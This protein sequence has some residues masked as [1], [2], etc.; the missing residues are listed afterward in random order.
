MVE[1]LLTTLT[2]RPGISVN[3]YPVTGADFEV[4]SPDIR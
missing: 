3:V 4:G 1:G 2:N